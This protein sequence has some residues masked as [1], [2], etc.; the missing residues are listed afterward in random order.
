MNDAARWGRFG[1]LV[2]VWGGLLYWAV[3]GLVTVIPRVFFPSPPATGGS[4][5]AGLI[6]LQT[7]LLDR[8]QRSLYSPPAGNEFDDWAAD[9][10]ERFDGLE[11]HCRGTSRKPYDTL[12][13]LRHRVETRVKRHERDLL[14]LIERLDQ[15]LT[16]SPARH[17]PAPPTTSP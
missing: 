17:S 4:C 5:R 10:D 9:W 1:G 16:S 15:E 8:A 6:G 12:A 3:V 14:P 2:L 13:Q 11:G 7:E